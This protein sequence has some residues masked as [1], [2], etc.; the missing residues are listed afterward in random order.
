MPFSTWWISHLGTEPFHFSLTIGKVLIVVKASLCGKP[1]CSC[2]VQ[3]W[4]QPTIWWWVSKGHS[5][6]KKAPPLCPPLLTALC[7]FWLFPD[8]DLRYVKGS[9]RGKTNPWEK[10]STQHTNWGTQ[11]VTTDLHGKATYL[12]ITSH[13]NKKKKTFHTALYC[14]TE[15]ISCCFWLLA[16]HCLVKHAHEYRHQH[17]VCIF[18][19]VELAHSTYCLFWLTTHWI[20]IYSQSLLAAEGR[21]SC[22]G[23]KTN[24]VRGTV[25]YFSSGFLDGEIQCL[26]LLLEPA[27]RK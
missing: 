8:S 2:E 27:K 10:P 17:L 23:K 16:Y 26:L 24:P 9:V 13:K 14:L 19:T 11:E 15:N 20:F 5:D 1:I 7:C 18:N 22:H 21:L 25:A 4:H 6:S 12:V 3:S